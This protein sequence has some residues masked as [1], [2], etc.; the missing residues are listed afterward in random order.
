[1][2]NVGRLFAVWMCLVVLSA[3]VAQAQ[4]QGGGRSSAMRG[5]P[6]MIARLL[7]DIEGLWFTATFDAKLDAAALEKLKPVC[8]KAADARGK[9]QAA[10]EAGDIRER[11]LVIK[12]I[13]DD[14]VKAAK[15]ALGANAA[16]LDTWF[17]KR[18]ETMTALENSPFM[19]GGAGR[20]PHPAPAPSTAAPQSGGPDHGPE[21]GRE[22]ITPALDRFVRR[23]ASP[24]PCLVARYE[25]NRLFRVH[26]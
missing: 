11:A 17:K 8:Q 24:G 18:E 25:V 26:E 10:A 3:G 9:E 5:G 15:D 1:M 19:G 13:G 23:F 4:A 6:E 22:E 2:K 14:M 7:C 12:A 21:E 16:K 20:A